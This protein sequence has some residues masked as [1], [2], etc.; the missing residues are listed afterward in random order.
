M[1][2]QYINFFLQTVFAGRA[3]MDAYIKQLT[4]ASNLARNG[5]GNR[6]IGQMLP[7]VDVIDGYGC[8]CYRRIKTKIKKLDTKK[9]T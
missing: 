8:W 7:N 1:K 4:E 9:L 2:L 6:N 5:I 3:Q